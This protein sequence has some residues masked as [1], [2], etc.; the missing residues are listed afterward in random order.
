MLRGGRHLAI[1]ILVANRSPALA[2]SVRNVLA[3]FG[4]EVMPATSLSLA[5]FLSQKTPPALVLSGLE[6]QDAQGFELITEMKADSELQS[7]PFIFVSDGSEDGTVQE[8]GLK[9]GA[10]KFIDSHLKN[11]DL[12]AAIESYL[13]KPELDR[14][15][16]STE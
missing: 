9:L 10:V 5:L 2:D 6:L 4:H 7:I 14:Q 13:I 12:L 1:R 8:E 15:P 16:E 11:D 3:P